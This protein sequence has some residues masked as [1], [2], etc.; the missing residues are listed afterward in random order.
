MAVKIVLTVFLIFGIINPVL[1]IRITEGWKL[2][3]KP[4]SA[5]VYRWTRILS[6]IAIVLVWIML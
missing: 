5:A 1:F 3:R 2:G 6:F 4:P